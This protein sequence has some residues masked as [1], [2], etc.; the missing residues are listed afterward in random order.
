MSR[1]TRIKT[2][3]VLRAQDEAAQRDQSRLRLLKWAGGLIVIGLVVAIIV[4]VVRAATNEDPPSAS[5]E[6]VAPAG[7]TSD[8]AIP[9]GQRGA[10]VTVEIY[11]DYMCPACGAFEAANGGELDRLLE[12]GD[13]RVLLRPI[14]FLDEQ[15]DGTEY[16]TRAANAFATVADGAPRSLWGFHRALYEAQPEEG[17][18]GLS[19]EEISDLAVAAGAPEE[20]VDRFGAGTH[21]GWVASVTDAAF[22]SGITGT[23][24][25]LIEGEEFEGDPYSTGDLTSAMKAAAGNE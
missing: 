16:S 23:P 17:T 10:S 13:V 21:E 25:V 18:S 24:T 19:D 15:S 4:V 2:Q 5:G 3:D 11:Y 8:G 14:S 22:D 7:A 6:V 9:V 12:A 1:Q 20:V